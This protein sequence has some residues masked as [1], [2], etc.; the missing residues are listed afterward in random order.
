MDTSTSPHPMLF[1]KILAELDLE[2]VSGVVLAVELF[3]SVA[4]DVLGMG[5]WLDGFLG[6]FLLR[7]S[8]RY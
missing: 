8:R 1:L 5:V 6:Q 3:Q 7:L 4:E 2:Q